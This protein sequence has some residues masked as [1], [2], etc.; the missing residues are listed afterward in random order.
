MKMLRRAGTLWA[1]AVLSTFLP[2][3]APAPNVL[4]DAQRKHVVQQTND[5]HYSPRNAGMKEFRCEVKP[6]WDR[7]LKELNYDAKDP[8]AA[9]LRQV[10]YNVVFDSDGNATVSHDDIQDPNAAAAAAARKSANGIEKVIGGFFKTWTGFGVSLP[11][12]AVDSEYK[13]EPVGGK[14]RVTFQ[15]GTSPV[16]VMINAEFAVEEMNYSSPEFSAVIRTKWLKTPKGFLL[17]GY[18]GDTSVK[19]PEMMHIAIRIDYQTVDGLALPSVVTQTSP[20]EGGT[21]TVPLDFTSYH[22]TKR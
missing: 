12:P 3:Q 8:A 2:A 6:E 5:L 21:A 20:T 4:N 18:E 17:V 1:L 13:V 7:F 9:L 10:H 19:P 15:E 16:V 14:Y 11:L 22:V